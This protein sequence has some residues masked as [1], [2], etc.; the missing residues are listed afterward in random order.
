[1]E[2]RNFDSTRE[3]FSAWQKTCEDSFGRAPEITAVGPSR[4]KYEKA[5]KGFSLF[6][7]LYATWADSLSDI[8][9]L[10]LEAMTKMQDRTVDLKSETGPERSRELYDIWMETYSGIFN[11]FLKSDHFA[12]DMGKFMSVFTDVQ[13]YNREMVEENLLVPSN[14]PTK[15]DIDEI[16]KELY[17]LRKQ[18]REL[19]RKLGELPEQK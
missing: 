12:S 10:S 14:L 19:S 4:E 16:Y 5:M 15:T 17:H 3:F 11:E 1:M 6:I 7:D 9:T 18:V 13:R 8:N 2:N